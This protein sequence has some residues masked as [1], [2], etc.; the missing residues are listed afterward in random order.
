MKKLFLYLFLLY[1]NTNYA[2]STINAMGGGTLLNGI[3]YEASI[4]EMSIVNT[5]SA[6]GT[7]LTQ[8][9]LQS[10]E[11]TPLSVEN[12][13]LTPEMEVYPNPTNGLLQLKLSK[14][15]SSDISIQILDNTGRILLVNSDKM[16]SNSEVYSFNLSNFASGNYFLNIEINGE[17]GRN[18]TNYQIVKH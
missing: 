10:I 15:P 11:I 14:I 3:V 17:G 18:L 7:I 13:G 16:K 4:G 8:G 5:L 6:N 12:I 2:Q 1:W 9:V